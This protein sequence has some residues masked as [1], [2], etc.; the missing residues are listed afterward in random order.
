MNTKPKP[1]AGEVWVADLGTLGK[2]RPVLVIY[3]PNPDDSR[4]LVI[5]APLTS[6][7]RDCHGEVNIAHVKWLPKPSAINIQGLASIDKN[8]LTKK[9]GALTQSDYEIVKSELRSLLD[10]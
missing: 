6:Q 4:M 5:V 2:I 1:R 7:I 3:Y 8:C 9:L 10:L